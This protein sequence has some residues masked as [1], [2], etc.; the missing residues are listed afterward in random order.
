MKW[1]AAASIVA[2][3]VVGAGAGAIATAARGNDA[4]AIVLS[5]GPAVPADGGLL[6]EAVR[7]AL[8]EAVDVFRRTRA[9]ALLHSAPAERF[10]QLAR[11]EQLQLFRRDE[12]WDDVFLDGDD[13][14]TFAFDRAFGAG[15]APVRS[16]DV[17]VPPSPQP[18]HDGVG[19]LDGS[20]CR[21]CH[22]VGGPD[23][24][25][26][27]TQRAR[28]RG[29][30]NSTM[31][32]VLRD[33]PHV[34][35]LG[36]VAILA[37]EMSQTLRAIRDEAIATAATTDRDV[38]FPLVAKGVSFGTLIAKPGGILDERAVDGIS[39]DLIVR[40]FGH[41]G[42]HA[43]LVELVDEALLVHHGI[44]TASQLVRE[45]A[46][47]RA[48]PDGDGVIAPLIWRDESAGAEA[49]AAQSVLL[50]SYL[51]V[52]GVPEVQPPTAPDL[53]VRW[54]QGRTLLDSVGCTLCHVEQLPMASD[55]L[56]LAA[57]AADD[58]WDD[59]LA[60]T[61]PL[62]RA[63]R[64]PQAVRTDFA[65]GGAA[66]GQTPVFLYSDLKRHDLGPALA[67]EVDEPLPAPVA[68]VPASQWLTRPL[69]GVADTA[70]YLHDGRAG[71]LHEAIVL[72]GGEAAG[73]RDAYLLLDDD[74]RAALRVF[75][76]SLTRQPTVVIE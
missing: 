68:A 9:T 46:T 20:S 26:T 73:S 3:G 22:F 8:D 56:I 23:G 33:A 6:P 35:G 30:G 76:L 5:R 10:E 16:D 45:G 59:R 27:S 62:S 75:L 51:A 34:M 17:D 7:G 43:D 63:Q 40:P 2:A 11:P 1:R 67:D 65:P 12:R 60:M 39:S 66:P 57:A 25:G 48:D 58:D 32:G 19:G 18:V 31:T 61:I 21:A 4:E 72:H 64:A 37:G 38:A 71:T 29:D 74:D 41:K 54:A 49:S 55:S 14:F 15:R 69:W 44:Q 50:A 42:R 36:P 53:L 24:A 52:L 47:D 28:L 70:P 13:A